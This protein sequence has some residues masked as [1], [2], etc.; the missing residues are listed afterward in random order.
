[1][2]LQLHL[3]T[4]R[5]SRWCFA[6]GRPRIAMV[7]KQ[8]NVVLWG[9]DVSPGAK[10]GDVSMPH[11]SGVVIGDGVVVE[12]GC[13]IMSGVV[14]GTPNPGTPPAGQMP[15]IRRGA[16]LGAGAK[17]IG[18]VVVGEG[19]VIGANSVVTRDIPAGTTAVGSPARVLARATPQ[20]STTPGEKTAK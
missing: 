19:A 8:I 12:D 1:M 13:Q 9:L 4:Y 11:P 15:T 10:L 16:T 7:L 2:P 5:A 14:L 3:R 20:T 17:I 18:P 6:N